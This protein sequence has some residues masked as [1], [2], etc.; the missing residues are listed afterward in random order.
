MKDIAEIVI[1]NI[2]YIC[3]G[4]CIGAALRKIFRGW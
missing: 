1:R 3:T 4:I 2:G